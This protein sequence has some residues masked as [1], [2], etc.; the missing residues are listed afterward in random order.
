MANLCTLS[1]IGFEVCSPASAISDRLIEANLPHLVSFRLWSE[2]VGN[3][4]DVSDRTM[5]Q[6][7][8]YA[9][10]SVTNDTRIYE[11]FSLFSR[12]QGCQLETIDLA[13]TK[14]TATGIAAVIEAWAR[15]PRSHLS[16][17]FHYC[18]VERG[19]VVNLC[20]ARKIPL[21]PKGLCC[22]GYQLSLF[23]R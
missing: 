3:P 11:C 12:R 20:Q 16:M 1:D 13:R 10:V 9:T 23:I 7:A 2:A 17:S 15:N 8:E 22:K 5:L 4:Y 21:T 18:D 14:I 19:D 6:I